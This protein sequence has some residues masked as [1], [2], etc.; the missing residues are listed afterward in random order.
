MIRFGAI[1]SIAWCSVSGPA[2]AA[3]QVLII[4]P[5][6]TEIEFTLG[7]T[8]HDVHGRLFLESGQIQFDLETGAATG[9]VAI[10][11]R[12]AVTG[13]KKRDK[14]MHRKVLESERFPLFVFTPTGIEGELRSSGA[15]E[16]T[17]SGTLA[18]H[19]DDHPVSIPV[20][21]E[22]QGDRV[23]ASATLTVPYVE[24]GLHQPNVLFLKVSPEVE[25]HI[26]VRANLGPAPRVPR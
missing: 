14:T 6:A 13:N 22:R 19:G 12:K 10:D 16:L 7:A 26:E 20:R 8:G 3:E 24:W 23:S 15:S 17:L 9:E 25:V 18:I 11:V 21:L 4:E 5:Q 1:L 2:L